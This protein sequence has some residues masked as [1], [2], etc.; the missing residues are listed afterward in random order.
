MGPPGVG[1]STVSAISQLGS[2][3]AENGLRDTVH[4]RPLR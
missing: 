1:K 4:Q 2:L 3:F